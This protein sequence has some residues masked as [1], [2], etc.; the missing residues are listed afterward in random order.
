MWICYTDRVDEHADWSNLL[1]PF[2]PREKKQTPTNNTT[3]GFITNS[4]WWRW[5]GFGGGF[6]LHSPPPTFNRIKPTTPWGG[7]NSFWHPRTTSTPAVSADQTP[8][9]LRS[10]TTT[11]T[12]LA[13]HLHLWLLGKQSVSLTVKE[14]IFQ[15][16]K[17][18]DTLVGIRGSE[19]WQLKFDC[20]QV[21][22]AW[23]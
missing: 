9:C 2:T 16:S 8:A 11:T 23:F 3:W 18:C 5:L 22:T 17:M 4:W 6:F 13:L 14:V 7:R 12:T 1:H 10:T 21:M 15:N 19:V 20:Q